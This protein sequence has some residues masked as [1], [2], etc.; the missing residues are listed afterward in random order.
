M[1]TR[2]SSFSDDGSF[3]GSSSSANSSV[4]FGPIQVREYERVLGQGESYMC[5][6]LGWEYEEREHSS[7]EESTFEPKNDASAQPCSAP[8]RFEI[9]SK[10]G[11]SLR[12]VKEHENA[13]IIQKTNERRTK[14]KVSARSNQFGKLLRK[15]LGGR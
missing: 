8:Q 13:K 15:L 4:S 2:R 1:N 9:L 5:L 12:E 7:L 6:E 11:Y 14:C 10:Y 3:S